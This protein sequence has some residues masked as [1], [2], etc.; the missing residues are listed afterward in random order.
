MAGRSGGHRV[1][2]MTRSPRDPSAGE[3]HVAPSTVIWNAVVPTL[4]IALILGVAPLPAMAMAI[5]S[6]AST[7]IYAVLAPRSLRGGRGRWVTAQGARRR[8][9]GGN[10]RSPV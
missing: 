9:P 4:A 5:A 7:V 6:A 10:Q 3:P 2:I 1:P 8:F